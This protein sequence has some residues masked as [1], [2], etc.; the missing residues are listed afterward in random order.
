MDEAVETVITGTKYQNIQTIISIIFSGL[1][2]LFFYLIPF[3]FKQ[4]VL[5]TINNNKINQNKSVSNTNS[6]L[7]KN[8]TLDEICSSGN[9]NSFIDYDNSFNN[10]SLNLKLFCNNNILEFEIIIF[11]YYISKV[12]NSILFGYFTDKF[13]RIFILFY[14]SILTIISFIFLFL[15]INNY[16]F[17]FIGSILIGACSYFYIFSSV[18]TCEYF[19][20][21]QGATVSA[22]N[23]IFGPILGIFFIF[24]LKIFNNLH[25]I[26]II[27]IICSVII[28]YYIKKY[29]NESPYY[30]IGRNRI[31]DCFNL[32]ET[33]AELN[34]RKNLYDKINQERYGTDKVKPITLTPNIIDIY[35]YNSQRKRLIMHI[36]IWIFSSI[37][38]HG[39]FDLLSFFRPIENFTIN[40][41][42]I[43]VIFIITQLSVGILSD[44]IG[45]QPCL[46]YSFYISS[47]SYI[48]YALTQ[49][50]IGIKKMFFYL[51]TAASSSTFSLLFIFS[52]EDFP[53]FIRGNVLGFLFGL[54]QLIALIGY[55]IKS[56]LVL[57]LFISFSNC[58]GGRIT[59]SMEDTYDLL[60]DDNVPEINVND[61]TLKK[62]KFRSLKCERKSSGSD[63]YFL[64][65]DD[66]VFN[67]EIQYI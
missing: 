16:F 37:S 25:F 65:S 1:N 15:G 60:L 27:L 47:V 53:T 30:L 7:S 62:K 63:L 28:F 43:F 3:L 6:T 9:I 22:L 51:S 52:A 44:N 39:I 5:Y 46:I 40:Y 66:E 32:L 56:E 45:R 59:E 29:F 38:F 36:L 12:I 4:P 34:E 67:K 2:S 41:I 33:F 64:T 55:Y 24:L 35:N 13:G 8:Y 49:E 11:V 42:I 10:Y 26:F 17:L 19:T 50:K 58:V 21:N 48:I 20:R 14:G 54:S 31:N 57:C 18:L 61:N 23:V